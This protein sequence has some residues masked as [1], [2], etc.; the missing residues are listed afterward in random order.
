MNELT[1]RFERIGAHAVR[2]SQG[3]TLS[4]VAG[5]LKFCYEEHGRRMTIASEP[6]TH[7]WFFFLDPVQWEP[8]F[9][10]QHLDDAEQRRVIQNVL[11]ALRFLNSSSAFVLETPSGTYHNPSY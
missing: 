6:G 4:Q 5:S 2:S 3:F 8:P 7:M 9:A 11:D 10:N 1:K